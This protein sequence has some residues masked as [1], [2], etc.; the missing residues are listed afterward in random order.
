MTLHWNEFETLMDAVTDNPPQNGQRK[1]ES[2]KSFL[3]NV[4]RK[5]KALEKQ[6]TIFSQASEDTILQEYQKLRRAHRDFLSTFEEAR[7]A[8]MVAHSTDNQKN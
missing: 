1:K 5:R 6:Q 7:S 8:L 3:K 2:T 4:T